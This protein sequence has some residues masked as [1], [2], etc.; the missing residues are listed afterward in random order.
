MIILVPKLHLK[1]RKIYLY[2][3]IADSFR[4]VLESVFPTDVKKNLS[5]SLRQLLRD[6]LKTLKCI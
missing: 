3:K 4:L 1:I 2:L 6:E 5:R